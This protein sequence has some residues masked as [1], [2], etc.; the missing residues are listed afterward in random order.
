MSPRVAILLVL[1]A[2]LTNAQDWPQWRGPARD[3]HSPDKDLELDWD[4]KPPKLLWIKPGMGKG[5]A[6]VSVSNGMI[7]TTGDKEGAQHVIATKGDGTIAWSRAVT[8]KEPKHGF[9]GSRCT[10]S[11]DGEWL[12]VVTSNG[13]IVCLSASSGDIKWQKD[14][15]KEWGGKMMS[16]WGYSESPLV[17]GDWV[18]CTPGGS[19]GMI[20]A[21]DKITGEQ[22]W[23]SEAPLPEGEGKDGAGYSSV[24]VSNAAGVKQYVTLVGRG[25]IGVRA[26]DGKLLWTYNQVANE[27]ANIPTPVCFGDYVFG[28]SGYGGGGSVLLKLTKDGDDIAAKEQYWLDKRTLQNHHGGM[29]RV[30]EHIYCGHGHNKGFPACLDIETGKLAWG[31]GKTRGVGDGSAAVAVVGNTLIF[32]YQTGELALI[33]ATPEAYQLKG[34]L[35]PEFQKGRTWAHPVVVGGKMYLREQDKLM[36]YEL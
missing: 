15:R 32:R 24:V 10:P 26:T 21:L 3:G 16:S 5:Y 11:I 25:L 7:Y 17:D 30:G 27:T 20:V 14:F 18:L 19:K 9:P 1:L 28:S 4:A 33:A 23:A 36:C 12:Y 29:V 8:P 35:K 22:V 13:S 2:P 6:S 31:G 34:V